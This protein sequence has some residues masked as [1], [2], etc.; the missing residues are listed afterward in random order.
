MVSARLRAALLCALALVLGASCLAEPAPAQAERGKAHPYLSERRSLGRIG[1]STSHSIF[2]GA[3]IGDQLTG[4]QPP[5]DMGAVAKLERML[6]KSMSLVHFM[7]PFAHCSSSDCSYYR[8]PDEEMQRIRNHGSIPFFSWSSQAIPSK[9]DQPDFQLGD[10]LDGR[11]DDFIRG[12]AKDARRWGHPFFLRFNWEMNGDWFPWA[13]GA[14]GNRPGEYVASWRHVH[15]LFSE[16]GATN[17]TWVWCPNVDFEGKLQDLDEVYPGDSYVDWTCLD[18]YNS[19]TNPGKDDRWRSFEEI[20][21]RTYHE[22]IERIAPGKPMAI[23]E[24]GSSEMGG[25]KARWITEMLKALPVRYPRIRAMV[26]LDKYEDGLDW[27]IETSPGAVNAFA[28]GLRNSAYAG[29]RFGSYAAA[30]AIRPAGR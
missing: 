7:A 6:G 25:S 22:I 15:D 21:D 24:I 27:P 10:L 9:E 14:N 16:V 18:G 8:F 26:W 13:E 3:H 23:G 20:Y 17:A 1:D 29:A 30:R 2:W 12:W 28:A 19:G 5:W 4:N 11:Y